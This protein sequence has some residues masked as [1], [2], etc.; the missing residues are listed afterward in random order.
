MSAT[1]AAETGAR[2]MPRMVLAFGALAALSAAISLC[3]RVVGHSIALGGYTADKAPHEIVIGNNVIVAPSNMI[4]QER[5]RRDGI[6]SRLDLFLRWP[7]MEGYS[8]AARNDF[9][10]ADGERRILFLTFEPKMMSR[11]MS[12]RFEPIYRSLIDKRGRQGP[13]GLVT[14]E[15]KP[16]SGYSNEVL[17]V[18]PR[19]G[20][21]PFV[22]RCLSGTDAAESLAPCERDIFLAD[23]L[24]LTYRFPAELLGEW[25]A[26]EAAVRRKAGDLIKTGE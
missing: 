6:A 3:G 24:S 15:F 14:Y 10:A 18:A 20:A 11:D 13:A 7:E 23:E 8:D 9:N 12:G 26:L 16:D 19:P 1:I 22:A 21:E 17:A 5:A 25:P 2:L 4:R